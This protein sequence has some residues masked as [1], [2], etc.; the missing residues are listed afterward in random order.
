MEM[1]IVKS[2]AIQAMRPMVLAFGAL[3]AE[4]TF[5]GALVIVLTEGTEATDDI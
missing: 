4:L 1:V 3:T 2:P 5:V